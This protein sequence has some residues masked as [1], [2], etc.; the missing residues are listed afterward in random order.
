MLLSDLL[1]FPV[2]P[3]SFL[4]LP[5]FIPGNDLP[6][7]TDWWIRISFSCW[8]AGYRREEKKYRFA[9][10]KQS[11]KCPFTVYTIQCNDDASCMFDVNQKWFITMRKNFLK[12]L[13][14]FESIAASV[15]ASSWL[16]ISLLHLSSSPLENA[17]ASNQGK[18]HINWKLKNCAFGLELR[19]RKA[20]KKTM[21]TFDLIFS[22]TSIEWIK[23]WKAVQISS[24]PRTGSEKHEKLLVDITTLW[25]FNPPPPLP[26]LR[27]L[28]PTNVTWILKIFK[29]T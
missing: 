16:I 27:A 19:P 8:S 2:L 29:A 26:A 25:N 13:H 21:K 17:T 6:P 12:I 1:F 15:F 22:V 20:S 3:R 18:M 10:P 9:S 5:R 23:V 7:Y 28:F 11:S 4:F 24:D 14:E